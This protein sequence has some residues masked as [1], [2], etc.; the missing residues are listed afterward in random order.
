MYFLMYLT[1]ALMVYVGTFKNDFNKDDA[2]KATAFIAICFAGA[3]VI[4]IFNSL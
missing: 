3:L 4:S 2:A 1:M